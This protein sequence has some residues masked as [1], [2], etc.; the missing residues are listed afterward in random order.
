MPHFGWEVDGADGAVEGGGCHCAGVFAKVVVCWWRPKEGW[1]N[2]HVGVHPSSAPQCGVVAFCG[3]E[4]RARG[5]F[6]ERHV[7]KDV[8][9]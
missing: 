4:D 2:G 1:G 8:C 6:G 7:V 3:V 5:A 9:D